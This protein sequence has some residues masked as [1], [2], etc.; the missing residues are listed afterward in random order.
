MRTSNIFL[1]DGKHRYGDAP[2]NSGAEDG[3]LRACQPVDKL[4]EDE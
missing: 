3:D 1:G 4:L 2:A